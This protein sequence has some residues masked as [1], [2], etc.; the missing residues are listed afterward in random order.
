[1]VQL[2][3][4]VVSAEALRVLRK[5]ETRMS[6]AIAN[7]INRT[8]KSVQADVRKGLRSRFTVRSQFIE[9]QAAIIK[10]FAS[11]KRGTMHAKVSV[12]QPNPGVLLSRFEEGGQRPLRPGSKNIAVAHLGGARPTKD[13]PIDPA[14]QIKKLRLRRVGGKRGGKHAAI[15]GAANTYLVPR[16]GIFQNVAG[17]KR[18]RLLYALTPSV[19]LDARLGFY[20][21]AARTTGREFAVALQDE[22]NKTLLYNLGR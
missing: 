7:A 18:G 21:T 19:R 22:V 20:A 4:S 12:G 1:M 13:A 17:Q 5:S 15:V 10:P 2:E 6:Y 9:R 3:V 16:V 14:L 11:A 8:V